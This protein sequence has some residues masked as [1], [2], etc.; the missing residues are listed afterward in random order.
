MKAL[1][2]AS[3]K[4]QQRQEQK[5]L[6]TPA[7]FAAPSVDSFNT[8]GKDADKPTVGPPSYDAAMDDK[9]TTPVEADRRS[10]GTETTIGTFVEKQKMLQ[11]STEPSAGGE[12]YRSWR[13]QKKAEKAARKAEKW[14]ERARRG[15][16]V[17]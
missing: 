6:A 16:Y 9:T 11:Q 5:R 2:V 12:Q 13:Q 14:A 17:Y 4:Y 7:G 15:G 10:S 8:P 1:Q 3:H